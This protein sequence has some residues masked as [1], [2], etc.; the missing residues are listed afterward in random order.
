[1][2]QKW[3]FL[4]RNVYFKIYLF[5]KGVPQEKKVE[6]LVGTKTVGWKSSLASTH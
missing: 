2:H 5:L 4:I 1:M 6:G 3:C